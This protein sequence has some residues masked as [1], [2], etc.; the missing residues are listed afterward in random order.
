MMPGHSYNPETSQYKLKSALH[1]TSDWTR[2]WMMSV[3]VYEGMNKWTSEW[4]SEG[5]EIGSTWEEQFEAICISLLGDLDNISRDLVNVFYDLDK[6][7]DNQRGYKWPIN[8]HY[9]T[10]VT[11]LGSEWWVSEFTRAWINELPSEGMRVW[12]LAILAKGRDKQL[13]PL[14]SDLRQC[15][16]YVGQHSWVL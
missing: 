11:E 4:G 5:V 6:S 13:E 12:R 3:W 2:K 10:R 8:Q 7:L 9:T 16:R 15:T 14:Q 1:N